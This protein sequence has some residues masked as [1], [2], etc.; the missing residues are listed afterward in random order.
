LS[1]RLCGDKKSSSL[2]A[3]SN[4]LD[5]CEIDLPR[6]LSTLAGPFAPIFGRMAEGIRRRALTGEGSAWN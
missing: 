5:D 3:G 4:A 6:D 2:C 1:S